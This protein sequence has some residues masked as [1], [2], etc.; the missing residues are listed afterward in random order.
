TLE[1]ASLDLPE[2]RIQIGIIAV[3]VE[4]G[5]GEWLDAAG[6][7]EAVG[8]ELQPSNAQA[9]E[10]LVE[11]VDAEPMADPEVEV[12]L[13]EV[14][15]ALG[16]PEIAIQRYQEALRRANRLG[17][18]KLATDLQAKLAQAEAYEP[19]ARRRLRRSGPQP[20]EPPATPL[21]PA[22]P[23]STHT[24]APPAAAPDA[25]APAAGEPTS[26]AE[27]PLPAPR[28]EEPRPPARPPR[29]RLA[30]ADAHAGPA[31]SAARRC[32]ACGRGAHIGGRA[33]P[34]S[35]PQGGAQHARAPVTRQHRPGRAHEAG[36]HE[37]S[38]G[39]PRAAGE[40]SPRKR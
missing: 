40:P 29:G 3:Q 26:A 15:V 24:P 13:G 31:G 9:I 25:A 12:A 4:L 36:G 30:P 18:Q 11:A 5:R 32:C 33:S 10:Q 7:I 20:I 16:R 39:R 28:K 6:A 27:P 8:R 21:Q 1:S 2:I 19:P 22:E 14:L 38:D 23:P 35:T 37:P 34:P 17:R